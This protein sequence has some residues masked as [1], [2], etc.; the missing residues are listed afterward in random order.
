MINGAGWV[1]IVGVST[2]S[3]GNFK[4]YVNGVI[5]YDNAMTSYDYQ[6]SGTL[7]LATSTPG[8]NCLDGSLDDVRLYRRALTQTEVTELY[9]YRA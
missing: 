9:N 7:I 3:L 1:H 8:V 6:D 2:G 5:D 4:I